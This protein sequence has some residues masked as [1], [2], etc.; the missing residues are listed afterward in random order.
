MDDEASYRRIISGRGGSWQRPIRLGL[1]CLEGLYAF[2]V[3][4][5]NRR[6]D[7]VGPKTVLPIPVVSVGNITAG[8]TGKTPLVVELLQR[9]SRMG[10]AP[11]VVSRGYKAV[12]GEP[13]DE[14][15]FIERQVPGVVCL[16]D[17]NRI[18][19][20]EEA[21]S[22]FGADVIVLDDGF[23]HRRIARTL[24]IVVIDATC[25][26]GYGHLL[27][28][29]LLREPPSSLQRAH[30]VVM[31]RC[32]QV[33]RARLSEV[34]ARVRELAD[35]A[36]VARCVHRFMG[37]ERL[38]GTRAP[39]ELAGKRAVLFAAIGRPEAFATTVRSLG[40]EVAGVR[41]WPDHH[42]Y[43]RHEMDALLKIGRFPPHE[44]LLTTEKDAVKLARIDGLEHANIFV[45]KVA[46]DFV[47]DGGTILQTVL[48]ERLRRTHPS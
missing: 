34:M 11:A 37:I 22:R 12:P 21:H 9:L 46:I 3:A 25:P 35:S 28:R 47:D 1:R 10:F 18:R 30:L 5:R 13:N 17:A 40:V 14:E 27:P 39:I 23:Q 8:G 4:L 41:W 43:R 19:A 38:D 32:D 33:S 42:R 36:V 29:G 31:T 6:Y 26:F 2:G 7:R 15:R 16:A 20:A 24:D 44:L 45:V 48:E